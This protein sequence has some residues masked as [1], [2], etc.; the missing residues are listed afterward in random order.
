MPAPRRCAR[1]SPSGRR[2][3]CPRRCGGRCP[4]SGG[5]ARRAPGRTRSSRR[6]WRRAGRTGRPSLAA[7]I[8]PSSSFAEPSGSKEYARTP[9]KPRIAT[10]AGMSGWTATSGASPEVSTTSSWSSPSGS[11]KRSDPRRGRRARP[12]PP[13]ARP[14]R[15]A[16][17]DAVDDPVDHARAGAAGDRARVLEERQ[18]G[19]GRGVLVAV[20]EVVDAR[21]VLVDRLRGQPQPQHARVEVDV[22]A[23]VA[24]DGADV[25]DAVELLHGRASSQRLHRQL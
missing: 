8:R 2:R 9:S 1:S 16:Q 23:G 17:P 5:R 12:R 14:R 19:A 10:S 6:A 18:V 7:P 21:I 11:E 13:G 3:R 24:G 20:E 22:A 25:V 15:R 4:R